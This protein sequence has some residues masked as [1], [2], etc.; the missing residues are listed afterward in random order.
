MALYGSS[1]EYGLHCLI[2]L[3]PAAGAT[4]AVANGN[5]VTLPARD[6][7]EFQGV[8]PSLVAKIFTK[9]QRAG[10]VVSTEG[11]KGGYRLARLPSEISVLDVIDA[12]EGDKPLFDCKQIQGQC[13]AAGDQAIDGPSAQ[14]PQPGSSFTSPRSHCMIHTVML[15]AEQAM[16]KALRSYSLGEMASGMAASM[17]PRFRNNMEQWFADRLAQRN[18][19]TSDGQVFLP[20]EEVRTSAPT[21]EAGPTPRAGRRKKPS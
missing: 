1:V 15:E 19:L 21:G 8:S 10:L 9:L 16:R 6:L 14:R 5:T 3:V 7:A 4:A 12:I 18:G 20:A 11:K 2:Y 17:P 13:A